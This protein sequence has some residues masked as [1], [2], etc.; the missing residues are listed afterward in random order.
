MSDNSHFKRLIGAV[1]EGSFDVTFSQMVLAQKLTS[2]A[3]NV[4][5]GRRKV[6]V[7]LHHAMMRWQGLMSSGPG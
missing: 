4:Y 5:D 2:F 7:G 1:P 6:E 3:W